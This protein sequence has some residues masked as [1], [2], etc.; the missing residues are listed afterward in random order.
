M[1]HGTTETGLPA[2]AADAAAGAGNVRELIALQLVPSEEFR[3]RILVEAIFG[4]EVRTDDGIILAKQRDALL[5]P[6]VITGFSSCLEQIGRGGVGRRGH[7]R[8]HGG[9]HDNDR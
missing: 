9:V 3:R 1:R 4:F 7:R 8:R 5:D 2:A 6:R